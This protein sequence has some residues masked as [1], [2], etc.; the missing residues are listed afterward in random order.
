MLVQAIGENRNCFHE[1]VKAQHTQSFG[2]LSDEMIRL[3]E[4]IIDINTLEKLHES[5]FFLELN[6]R[7]EEI[8]EAQ[9]YIRVDL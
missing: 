4:E 2:V 3:R 9:T 6:S 1:L 8:C 5:L 7:Q